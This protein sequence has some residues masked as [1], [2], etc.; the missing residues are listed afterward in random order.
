MY[1]YINIY[2]YIYI[3]IYICVYIY[4]YIYIYTYI[5]M[6]RCRGREARFGGQVER[7]EAAVSQSAVPSSPLQEHSFRASLDRAFRQQKLLSSP[8]LGALTAYLSASPLLRRGVF[9]TDIGIIGF[10]T[11]SGQA[12]RLFQKG[13][14]SHACC[15]SLFQARSFRHVA[16]AF[17]H[18]L[19]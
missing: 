19:P 16:V 3:Y 1:I 18:A 2:I 8:C 17:C 4:I 14:R 9:F 12:C 15:H 5:Y 7:S 13:H 6:C 11:G 10:Q